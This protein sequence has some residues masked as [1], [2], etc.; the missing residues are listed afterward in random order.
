[1]HV[2]RR[3]RTGRLYTARCCCTDSDVP[4]RPRYCNVHS[5]MLIP[6]RPE[7]RPEAEADRQRAVHIPVHDL[8]A[9]RH[10]P[11]L[12]AGVQ[13]EARSRTPVSQQT[14]SCRASPRS[15]LLPRA[16]ITRRLTSPALPVSLVRCFRYDR[17]TT[18]RHS[19]AP[20]AQN[21]EGDPPRGPHTPF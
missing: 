4:R 16:R 8:H 20:Q 17:P 15:C 6:R 21:V 13:P 5:H 1:M 7:E 14:L 18:A 10:L 12:A 2:V 11:P 3:T 19:S 9:L